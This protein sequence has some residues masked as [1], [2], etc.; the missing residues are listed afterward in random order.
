MARCVLTASASMYTGT[1]VAPAKG[2][3]GAHRAISAGSKPC[4]RPWSC[5]PDAV[6]AQPT[7]S[8]W[9]AKLVVQESRQKE[10]ATRAS[11]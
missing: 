4:S 9:S 11:D 1:G 3:A 10:D 5:G 2:S 7:S 8:A 6:F